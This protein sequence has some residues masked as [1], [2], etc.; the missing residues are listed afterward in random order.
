M[1]NNLD[2]LK[3]GIKVAEAFMDKYWEQLT[4]GERLFLYVND[5]TVSLI[6]Q[7]GEAALLG[8]VF[9]K[10]SWKRELA[11]GGTTFDWKREIDGVRITISDAEDCDM[12]GSPVPEKAFPI[13][14]KNEEE[15]P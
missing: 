4:A 9:G 10:H 7:R 2:T 3:S 14:I 5:G 6:A 1:R 12:N 15:K 11:Y 13:M 8:E